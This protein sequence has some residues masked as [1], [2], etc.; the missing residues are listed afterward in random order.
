MTKSFRLNILLTMAQYKVNNPSNYSLA[1][2]YRIAR[3]AFFVA[4]LIV[5]SKIS[6]PLFFSPVPFT[7]Q[8]LAIFL[9]GLL[10]QPLDA[11]LVIA[12]YLLAG[13]VGLPVFAKGGG[14]S[15][16]FGPTGG[17]LFGFLVGGTLISYLKLKL[18]GS[19]GVLVALFA[20]LILI[21]LFG[22]VYLAFLTKKGYLAVLKIAVFPFIP[23]DVIKAL[24][25]FAVYK[26]YENRFKNI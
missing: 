4:L 20:G 2:S 23:F 13:A 9:I 5:F 14:L 15:Y 3:I 6:I 17:F 8:L 1:A 7:F 11:F 21:Y 25:A 16:L 10:L 18:K 26:G 12:F 19:A 24:I 22:S